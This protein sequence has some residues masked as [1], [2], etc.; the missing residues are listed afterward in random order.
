MENLTAFSENKNELHL[1]GEMETEPGLRIRYYDKLN[2]ENEAKWL[3]FW[4]KCRHSHFQQHPLF[5]QVQQAQKKSVIYAMGEKQGKLVCAGVFCINPLI[6]G[7][8]RF[9]EAACLRGP[10]FDDAEAGKEFLAEIT[11]HFK[12]QNIRCIRLCPYWSFPEAEA[13]E[14][15]LKE[16]GFEYSVCGKESRS[17]TGLID[18]STSEAEL[19]AMLPKKT[20]YDIRRA[21][22]LGVCVKAAKSSNEANEFYEHLSNMY[23]HRGIID[24]PRKEFES[25]FNIILR[26][27]DIAIVLNAYHDQE[28]IGGLYLFRGAK[29]CHLSRYVVKREFSEQVANLTIAPSLLWEGIKWAKSRNCETMDVER[30]EQNLEV[31]HLWHN[32]MKTKRDF[33]AKPAQI[34]APHTFIINPLGCKM[35]KARAFGSKIV[36]RVSAIPY[37]LRKAF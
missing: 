5:G 21:E 15:T 6:N 11:R 33:N 22:R 32:F 17:N 35:C 10:A 37:L 7:L 26:H 4:Q 19:F 30:Y 12:N 2:E 13:V 20:R 36:R 34:I 1:S 31:T 8:S 9:S 16:T 25:I 27:G 28:F 14:T 23:R 24:T 29:T 3:E 18:L